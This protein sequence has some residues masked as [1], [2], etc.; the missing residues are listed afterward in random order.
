VANMKLLGALF[1][2]RHPKCSIT[3]KLGG[4]LSGVHYTSFSIPVDQKGHLTQ[5]N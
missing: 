5:S 3:H 2:S 1:A 4:A